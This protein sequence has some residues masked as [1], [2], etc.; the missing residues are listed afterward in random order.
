MK[1]L[2]QAILEIENTSVE[3][4]KTELAFLK[5]LQPEIKALK[6]QIKKID[7][8]DKI[9]F[10]VVAKDFF[11]TVKKLKN[12]YEEFLYPHAAWQAFC[13][14]ETNQD[15]NHPDNDHWDTENY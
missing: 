3:N 4:A 1:I 15:W 10:K 12:Q 9:A 13:Q 5:S 6:K 11:K 14:L 7:A 2:N 8:P